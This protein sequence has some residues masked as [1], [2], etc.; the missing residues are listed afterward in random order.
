ML[1]NLKEKE[2]RERRINNI[3]MFNIPESNSS[4]TQERISYDT[5]KCEY[6]IRNHLGIENLE[7][8]EIIRLG[9]RDNEGER[10]QRPRPVRIKVS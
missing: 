4:S 2:E 7:I 3:V 9:K 10:N 1:D 8:Q 6:V 5:I